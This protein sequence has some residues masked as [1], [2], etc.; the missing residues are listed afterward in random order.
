MPL[1]Y[2]RADVNQPI[3]RLK[4]PLAL[5]QLQNILVSQNPNKIKVAL[6]IVERGRAR[7]FVELLVSRLG[8]TG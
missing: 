4:N 2:V 3:N 6:E 8:L 5:L 1:N 7:A